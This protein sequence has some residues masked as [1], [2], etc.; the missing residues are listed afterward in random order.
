M[1]DNSIYMDNVMKDTTNPH[2]RQQSEAVFAKDAFTA[3]S[4]RALELLQKEKSASI[5][6]PEDLSEIGPMVHPSLKNVIVQPPKSSN[7]T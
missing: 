4:S 7:N 2:T 5:K 1:N 3:E 6:E